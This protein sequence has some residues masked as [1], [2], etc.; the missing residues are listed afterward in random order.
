[1]SRLHRPDRSRPVAR[2]R[3][4]LTAEILLPVIKQACPARGCAFPMQGS[5]AAFAAAIATILETAPDRV[6]EPLIPALITA[7]H[8][9][10]SRTW[11]SMM[12]APLTMSPFQQVYSNPSEHQ[13]RFERMTI[14]QPS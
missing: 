3:D 4:A 2:A 7:R 13:R 14:M 1:M 12:N 8:A 6:S 10:V 9:M 11:A 5:E